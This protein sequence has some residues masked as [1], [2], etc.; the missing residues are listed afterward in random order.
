MK[1]HNLAA[2]AGRWS[3][4]HWKT[5]TFSWIA[6]VV[7]AIVAGTAAGLVPL[8]DSEQATGEA[9]RAQAILQDAGFSQPAAEIVLVQSTSQTV[10]DPE[11]RATVGRV[12]AKL[13]TLAQVQD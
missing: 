1:N 7:V 13:R 6:F 3:A 8:S 4:S 9:A 2:R 12:T 5:A 10:A 11:F